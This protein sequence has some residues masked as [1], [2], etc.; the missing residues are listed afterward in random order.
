MIPPLRDA[1]KAA[2]MPPLIQTSFQRGGVKGVA[3]L[4]PFGSKPDLLVQGLK[5]SVGQCVCLYEETEEIDAKRGQLQV[6][7]VIG[8]WNEEHQCWFAKYDWD[9]LKWAPAV[10][11]VASDRRKNEVRRKIE[12]AVATTPSPGDQFDDISATK[13]DEGIVDYFRGTTWQGHR[14]QDLRYHE[15]A[16][17]F[18]RMRL[19]DIGFQPS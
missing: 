16:L 6:D 15:A 11:G 13:Q 1:D 10:P 2:G 4:G 3:L 18:L 12:L 14:V 9:A 5:L 17:S 8:G 7:A 19:F